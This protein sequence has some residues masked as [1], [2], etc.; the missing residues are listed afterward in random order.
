MVGTAFLIYKLGKIFYLNYENINK[1]GRYLIV[2]ILFNL[3][4]SDS[5]NYIYS[6]VTY[7]FLIFYILKAQGKLFSKNEESNSLSL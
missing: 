1:K 6:A 2:F 5:I 3:V 4:K 7:Y